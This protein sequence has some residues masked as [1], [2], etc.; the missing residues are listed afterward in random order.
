M[1]WISR[2]NNHGRQNFFRQLWRRFFG[3]PAPN[4]GTSINRIRFIR[5]AF[6]CLAI[7][8]I[9]RLARLQIV[10]H[11][12]YEALA[13][14]QH[15]VYKN[16]FPERGEI[17][18][19]DRSGT[20]FP[21]AANRE[22]NMVWADL[23]QVDDPT[24][25]AKILAE[26]LSL[27]ELELKAKLSIKD[28]P[29]EPIAHNI[30]DT[31]SDII[32]GASLS[33]IYLRPETSRTYP[34]KGF[35]GHVLGF[36]G[37]SESGEMS[38]KYGLEGFYNEILSGKQ[39]FLAA[40]RDPAGRLIPVAGRSLEPAEDGKDLVLSIDRT[41]QFFV[42][43]KLHAAVKS[44]GADSGSV[45]IMD[46]KTGAVISMCGDPDFDPNDY[47]NVENISYFN[48]PALFEAY[49]PGSIF[50]AIT[51]SA[52]IDTESVG[53]ETTYT[54]EG[55]VVIGP[56]TIRNSDKK[57]HGVRT[58]TQVLEESLNTGAIFAMEQT[59]A[60]VFK[61][62]V[63]QFGFG[64]PTGIDLN[65]EVAA[66]ISSLSQRGDIYPATAS[67]GQGITVTP[68]QIAA[69]FGAL[70]NEGKLMKPYVV[71][72]ILETDKDPIITNP[73][74]VRQVV[75]ARTATLIDA[76]LVS[77]V[78]NGHGKRAGV[79]G[80]W[81]AGKTGTAQVP[82]KDGPGYES[83]LTNGTFA[84]FGPVPNPKFV[85]VVRIDHPRDVQ[86]AESSAAPLFGEIAKFLLQYWQVPPTRPID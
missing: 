54:D 28:D 36:L 38:G 22:L 35:G 16:L 6:L 43:E 12:F 77:V 83:G 72:E 20:L 15:E 17:L 2:N 84:G 48:N 40:E 11:R 50:K 46:P 59:G 41:I 42:C 21:V 76:M 65:S 23:R 19:R 47:R 33:G 3:Q 63:E 74:M 14:G 26:A 69:A 56:H 53:P 57:A 64:A 4:E 71:S 66:D 30:T 32:K 85:M 78:E 37:S 73:Q 49:E 39:G 1:R 8:V 67:F 5:A 55:E 9:I 82:R 68:I 58:M 79:R 60:N 52:A 24:R 44:H 27:D 10:D 13:S 29:F 61:K 51:M 7:L 80:Y 25:A 18:A 75:S 86:F 31:A 70:A 45:I 34:E 81:I 62:Y